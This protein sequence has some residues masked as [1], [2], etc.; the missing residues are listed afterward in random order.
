MEIALDAQRTAYREKARDWLARNIPPNWK[1]GGHWPPLSEDNEEAWL[2]DWERK[3]YAAGYTGISWPKAYGGQGQDHLA[4]FIFNEELGRLQAPESINVIGRELVGPIM[5]SVGTEAQKAHYVPRIL[6]MED[7]W[8]QGFSE[9]NAGSDL[10]SI[11]TRAIQN[12][13][14]W[15]I[16]G[17]K[18][19]TSYAH[20]ATHCILLARTNMEVS[21]YQGMSLFMV[22]MD[23]PGIDVRA[24]P[25]LGGQ[26]HFNEVF[27]T[28]VEV[29][30]AQMIGPIHGGWKVAVEVLGFERATTRLYRQARFTE[31]LRTLAALVRDDNR[32]TANGA[33]DEIGKI[34]A[35]LEIMRYH[36]L[37]FIS[38]LHEGA[39][40]GEEASFLKLFWS[41]L[42]QR[43]AGLGLT[44]LGSEFNANTPIA[45]QFRR[46]YFRARGET[47]YAG[48]SQIQRNILAERV[49]GL[50]R[51]E[52]RMKT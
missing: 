20:F 38:R 26:R 19:W 24:I 23:T 29:D 12:G 50:P 3:L 36:N 25:H 5:L 28:D 49:L 4:D 46:I 8:C 42:H 11:K 15:V 2:I 10:A 30:G 27:F 16:N 41:Q 47:I 6:K 9:P 44:L 39:R 34:A 31:E 22:R 21:P 51:G 14:R 1:N 48:S 18:I 52:R 37:R 7:I 40:I 33:K 45:E 43:I 13:D 32:S 17:Q 35:E